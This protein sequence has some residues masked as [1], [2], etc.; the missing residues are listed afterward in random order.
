MLD[1]FQCLVRCSMFQST[2]MGMSGRCLLS[3]GPTHHWDFMACQMCFACFI[4]MILALSYADFANVPTRRRRRKAVTRPSVLW[5]LWCHVAVREFRKKKNATDARVVRFK[6]VV[7]Q[8]RWNTCRRTIC[9][10]SHSAL[11]TV[12]NAAW[13]YEP[14]CLA[15]I[16]RLLQHRPQTPPQT[17]GTWMDMLPYDVA[18]ALRL[19]AKYDFA[20]VVGQPHETSQLWGCDDRRRTIVA[21]LIMWNRHSIFS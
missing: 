15:G 19:Y 9:S 10:D 20:I 13:D 7:R 12:R 5:V 16:S 11:K 18:T 1:A 2:T 4:S 3:M 21:R 8:S 17:Q 14:V 6:T